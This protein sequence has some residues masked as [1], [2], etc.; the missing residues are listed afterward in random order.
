[1]EALQDGGFRDIIPP[2]VFMLAVLALF[3][4]IVIKP[5]K[6]RQKKHG[7]LIENLKI[8]D[9]IVS[10]GGIYGKITR[11]GE[12]TIEVEVAPNMRLTFDRRAVR[13]LQH[14]KDED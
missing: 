1:M 12:K 6:Q 2:L 7:E 3:W 5:A 10:V 8:G 14:E 4:W 11:A 13:R 9:E